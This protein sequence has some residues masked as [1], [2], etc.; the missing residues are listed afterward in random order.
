MDG[1][2]GCLSN[3][4]QLLQFIHNN[5]IH[6]FSKEK[7][8]SIKWQHSV[9]DSHNPVLHVGGGGAKSSLSQGMGKSFCCHF[10]DP[11][12]GTK[13]VYHIKINEWLL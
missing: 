5:A 13:V 4:H 9:Y 10:V 2:N 11:K 12:F 6:R 7:E 1:S 3:Y 8:N